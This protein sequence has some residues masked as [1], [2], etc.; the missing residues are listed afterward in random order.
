MGVVRLDDCGLPPPAQVP[1]HWAH[2]DLD[3]EDGDRRRARW[4]LPVQYERYR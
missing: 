4:R 3:S 1:P 2:H